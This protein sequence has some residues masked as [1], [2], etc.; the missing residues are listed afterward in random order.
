MISDLTISTKNGL[1]KISLAELAPGLTLEVL[2]PPLKANDQHGPTITRC[3]A[4]TRG[5]I[6]VILIL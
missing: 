2:L 3:N 4:R 5:E 1:E 6:H